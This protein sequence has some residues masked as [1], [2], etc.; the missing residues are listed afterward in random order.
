ME[1]NK[2]KNK[3]RGAEFFTRLIAGILAILMVAGTIFTVVF[4]L[5]G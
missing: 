5:I 2:Q 4:Y 1:E 3:K